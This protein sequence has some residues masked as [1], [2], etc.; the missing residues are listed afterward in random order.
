MK[1]IPNIVS[2]SVVGKEPEKLTAALTEGGHVANRTV[3]ETI[4]R[5]AKR[6]TLPLF[7]GI[8]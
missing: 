5:I 4:M 6:R 3:L 7:M 1:F 8:L 2:K